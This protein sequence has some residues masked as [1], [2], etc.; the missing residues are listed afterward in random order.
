[1]S[2]PMDKRPYSLRLTLV[3]GLLLFVAVAGLLWAAHRTV[4]PLLV[5]EMQKNSAAVGRSVVKQFAGAV[6]SGIPLAQ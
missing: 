4:A 5:A 1:M 3:S 2:R 6:T